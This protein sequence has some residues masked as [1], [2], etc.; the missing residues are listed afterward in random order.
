MSLLDHNDHDI[1]FQVDETS[2]VEILCPLQFC[3][4]KI[5]V[6]FECFASSFFRTL[7][8]PSEYNASTE[9]KF[10]NMSDPHGQRAI[11]APEGPTRDGGLFTHGLQIARDMGHRYTDVKRSR[12]DSGSFPQSDV[13]QAGGIIQSGVFHSPAVTSTIAASLPTQS[14]STFSSKSTSYFISVVVSITT[15]ALTFDFFILGSNSVSFPLS[16][17][18]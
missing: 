4:C 8:L 3:G 15:Y 18:L 12:V 7:F 16:K 11:F 10:G 13:F 1:V 2:A 6:W 17:Y 14:E 9:T 5:S